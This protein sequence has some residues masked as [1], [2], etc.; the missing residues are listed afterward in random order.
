MKL[1]DTSR[2]LVTARLEP[3]LGRR[4]QP[5]GFPDLGPA[6]YQLP[7][8]DGTKML[9]VESEQSM[10]NRLEESL[11]DRPARRPIDAIA[12]LPYVEVVDAEGR[13]L[14]SSR[15]EPHRLAS[16]YIKDA[17]LDGKT[18]TDVL[19]DRLALKKGR[20]LDHRA[21][22]RAIARLDPLCLLHGVFLADQKLPGQPK[23][24]RAVTS[25]IE[26]RGVE[27]VQSGGVKRDDV[28]HTADQGGGVGAKEGYGFVPFHR[29]EFVAEEIVAPFSIDLEQLR[30]YG[31]G[32]A[33]TEALFTVA[34]LEIR[35]FLDAGLRLRTACDLRVV[36]DV[37]L[38][39]ADDLASE[40]P[41]L[42]ARAAED[43]GHGEVIRVTWG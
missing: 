2:L 17:K 36:E 24:A 10:A 32:D 25:F 3:L 29:T 13:F 27:R 5:T 9:L 21:I 39:S 15:L 19:L 16:A 8:D 33:A 38:P 30:G 42:I 35:R 11:W 26:A 31:L 7:G 14:T 43:F 6:E 40:L 41:G 12:G 1:P 23:V 34:L 18:G 4:F 28:Q 37:G 22:A 20:P